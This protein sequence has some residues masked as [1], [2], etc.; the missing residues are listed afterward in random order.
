MSIDL[1]RMGIGL[2]ILLC[3][4]YAAI[5][6]WRRHKISPTALWA[7]C[8]A[9]I[10]IPLGAQLILAGYTGNPNDLPSTWREVVAAAGVVTIGFALNYALRAFRN[11]LAADASAA[12]PGSSP[13]KPEGQPP[14]RG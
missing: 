10:G 7:V 4:A 2:G 8:A 11:A 1:T 5:C 6:M 13:S 3:V 14:S 9:G 12:V